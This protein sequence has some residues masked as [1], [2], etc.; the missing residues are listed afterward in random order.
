M[1]L[2]P[3]RSG[4]R[5]LGNRSRPRRKAEPE[6]PPGDRKSGS[7]ASGTTLAAAVAARACAPWVPAA[8]GANPRR[9]WAGG[10]TWE[11][12]CR[13][14][15]AT[16]SRRLESGLS[17]RTELLVGWKESRTQIRLCEEQHPRVG[18]LQA[19]VQFWTQVRKTSSPGR[20]RGA[21]RRPGGGRRAL[22]T[23]DLPPPVLTDFS[24]L[25]HFAVYNAHL[26][27]NL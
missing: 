1:A 23:G 2:L 17:G 22:C 19:G 4:G 6:I 21:Q 24:R 5:T 18:V 26:G 12:P 8:L 7:P 10:V 20:S 14:V 3:G 25:P 11:S 15:A 9:F 13:V 27:P 16:A